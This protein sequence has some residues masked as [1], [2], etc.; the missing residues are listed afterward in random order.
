M[1]AVF[2][3]SVKMERANGFM[4]TEAGPATSWPA[5]AGV[6]VAVRLTGMVASS[7][8]VLLAITWS[9]DDRVDAAG[10]GVTAGAGVLVA[11][12]GPGMAVAGVLVRSLAIGSM[13]SRRNAALSRLKPNSAIHP[14]A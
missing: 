8:V 13:K 4:P 10:V 12:G 5:D 9:V 14:C 11:A 6:V 7:P 2:A 1:G 3:G